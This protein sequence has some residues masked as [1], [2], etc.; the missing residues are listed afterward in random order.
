MKYLF[1]I[2]SFLLV[3][4]AFAQNRMLDKARKTSGANVTAEADRIYVNDN[5]DPVAK[6]Q[7]SYYLVKQF[8]ENVMLVSSV[9]TYDQG[10]AMKAE[11][12]GLVRYLY[13]YHYL[14]N[15]L[16]FSVQV[17]AM[18]SDPDQYHYDGSAVWYNED[19]SLLAKG[20]FDSGKLNGD[21]TEYDKNGNITV[22]KKYMAGE[23]FDGEAGVYEPL[24]G[25]WVIVTKRSSS[26]E[27]RLYNTFSADGTLLIE[28]INLSTAFDKPMK[29]SS[30]KPQS[31]LWKYIPSGSGP[32]T[33]EVYYPDGK[34]LGKETA[35]VSNGKFIA[36]ITQHISPDMVG[37]KYE[38][39]RER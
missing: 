38:F 18:K 39:E 5:W 17:I 33:L 8:V 14:N 32:G 4:P 7:A 11:E 9:P 34:L 24:L 25:K 27:K 16:A 37:K 35:E 22:Q 26:S 3:T 1:L 12:T 19:G 13:N 15:Q 30:P 21:Y 28:T 31:F 10:L 23:E 2:L 29:L 20:G 36:T 6:G